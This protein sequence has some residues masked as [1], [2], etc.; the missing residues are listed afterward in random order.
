[1]RSQVVVQ[2]H[3]SRDRGCWRRYRQLFL[4][5]PLCS[6]QGWPSNSFACLTQSHGR[7][8]DLRRC[9][10][11]RKDQIVSQ[12][13]FRQYQ[14]NILPERK[15]SMGA[16]HD[17]PGWLKRLSFLRTAPSAI[18]RTPTREH[19]SCSVR[20][21]IPPCNTSP[22]FKMHA[23]DRCSGISPPSVGCTCL[24]C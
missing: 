19:A 8:W 23:N 18:F 6:A 11:Q 24:P 2:S 3:L 4:L 7:S 17:F 5:R 21:V 20:C 22:N 15:V 9:G 14:T 1:M 10:L 13:L 16:Y 12:S